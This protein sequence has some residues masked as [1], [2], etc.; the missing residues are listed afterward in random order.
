M[1]NPSRHLL[2]S[3][4]TVGAVGIALLAL[5]PSALAANPGYLE[6]I[7]VSH[8]Q[9]AP[10]W[11]QARD[12]GV[13]F[14]IAKASE[15]RTWTD[16]QYAR[17][18][19]LAKKLGIP[20]GAYHFARP[21]KGANDAVIEADNFVAAA[22]LRGRDLLPVLDLEDDGGLGVRPLRRWVRA[23]LDRVELRLGVKPMIYVS[24]MFWRDKMGDSVWFANHGYRLWV[25]HWGVDQPS[26][27]AGNW[28]GSGWTVWQYDDCG[29]YAGIAGCADSDRFN[30]SDL[31][32]LTIAV[33]R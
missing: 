27:P 19:R 22:Q 20:F 9:G 7:D 10:R 4:L 11:R 18:H 13:Q 33:N 17:N 26:L 31:S 1:T 16:G 23:W 29:S 8:W 30:G 32:A 6:G 24:P 14:V 2:R 15:G 25:A 21:G 5:V 12:A 3:V 28:G